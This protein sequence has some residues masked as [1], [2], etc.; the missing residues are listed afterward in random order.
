MDTTGKKRSAI[1]NEMAEGTFPKH[2]KIGARAAAW[3]E[4]DIENWKRA[5]LQAA[6]RHAA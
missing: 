3:L 6:G 5:K 4:E 1:Y 2:F